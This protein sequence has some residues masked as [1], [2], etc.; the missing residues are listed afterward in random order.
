[1]TYKHHRIGED[2]TPPEWALKISKLNLSHV[3]KLIIH[4]KS[5]ISKIRVSHE[6]HHSN[7]GK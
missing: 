6:S 2:G 5:L 1:M 7:V 3:S 4:V